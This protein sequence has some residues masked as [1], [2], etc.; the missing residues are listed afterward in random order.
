M[1]K[2]TIDGIAFDAPAGVNL[3]EAARLVGITIPAFCYHPALKVVG[4]CRIC[5]V[6]VE[7]MP[8]LQPGCATPVRE[9]MVVRTDTERVRKMRAQVMEFLL[10]NHPLDCPVCDQ[11]GECDL[12]DFC[13]AYAFPKSRFEE[14]KRV[15]PNEER[16]PLGPHVFQNQNRCI[17]CTRCIRFCR[18]ISGT[19][20]LTFSERGHRTLVDVF[21]G[22]PLDNAWSACTADLCPVGALTVKDF[23]FKERVW[24]LESAST[25]CPHCGN[26]CAI[27]LQQRSGVVKRFLPR[28]DPEIN[29]HWLCDYGR[30]A[31]EWMNR[32]V[33]FE[34][35]AD[36]AEAAWEEALGALA[37]MIR[38]AKRKAAALASPFLTL[39]ELHLLKQIFPS[40]YLLPATIREVKIRSSAQWLTS[41]NLAP[42][43]AGAK[44]LGYIPY[45]GEA[46]EAALV[47]HHPLVDLPGINANSFFIDT[48]FETPVN[49][50]AAGLL[51]GA[52]FPEKEGTYLND[53]G[54]IR[55]TP[56]AFPPQ[57][58]ARP[59]LEYLLDLAK[60]LGKDLPYSTLEG[61]FRA[62]PLSHGR[63]YADL[64]FTVES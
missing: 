34:P 18:D 56:R 38:N 3:I 62:V 6:E 58:L 41:M 52:L 31:F 24:N 21:P 8:K 48:R 12:Q 20:E 39:E 59:A 45:R 27:E 63:G 26:G 32:S 61:V 28:P 60:L 57:G 55:F 40:V 43:A 4:Q 29:D 5:L 2:V 7:G 1:P 25:I 42:N 17:H 44:K 36:G 50:E 54:R 13:E 37:Q 14:A 19:G 35:F 15:N 47:F 11:A 64:P 16:R 9:G 33:I 46:L 51:P 23:R 22:A 53:H 30:F 10:I 49:S